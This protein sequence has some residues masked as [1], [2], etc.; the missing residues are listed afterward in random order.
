MGE[1][2][3]ELAERLDDQDMRVEGHLVV[4]STLGSMD[5][6][7]L[8]LE[9]LEKSIAAYDPKRQRVRRRGLG[10][11][12]GVVSLIVSGLFLWMK[13]MPDRARSRGRRRSRYARQLDHP[14]SIELCALS[15]Q[16]APSVA[17]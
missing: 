10:S 5:R 12:P 11:N 6:L 15:L 16:F 13:G 9:H 7:D 14:F 1:R 3:L 17:G 4:G 8:G 2:I